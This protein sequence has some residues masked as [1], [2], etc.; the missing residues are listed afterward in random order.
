MCFLASDSAE[1]NWCLDSGTTSV[2]QSG[3]TYALVELVDSTN[4][5]PQ[6]GINKY[7][8]LFNNYTSTRPN[9]PNLNCPYWISYPKGGTDLPPNTHHHECTGDTHTHTNLTS[10]CT[11]LRVTPTA[12]LTRLKSRRPDDHLQGIFEAALCD[13]H[14][15]NTRS[16]PPRTLAAH[17]T[18]NG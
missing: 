8:T 11:W 14:T 7:Y 1:E 5:S 18:L 6:E 4:R 2:T 15:R 12:L 9:K 3:L 16:P 10:L 17:N 13:V